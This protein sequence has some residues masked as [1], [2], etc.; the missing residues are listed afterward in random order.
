M[1]ISCDCKLKVKGCF[2]QIDFWCWC[3]FQQYCSYIVAVSFI[4]GVLGLAIVLSV[5]RFTV[6]D[7]PFGIFNIVFFYNNT[8]VISEV[9][10][11]VTLFFLST[12]LK[13]ADKV[14]P[15]TNLKSKMLIIVHVLKRICKSGIMLFLRQYWRYLHLHVYVY[16]L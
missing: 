12:Y 1:F 6:S 8:T 2:W 11:W 10:V 15:P 4:G 7:Y 9:K 13:D 14:M 16:C 5:L 3:H